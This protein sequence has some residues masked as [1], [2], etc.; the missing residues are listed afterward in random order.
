M[1]PEDIEPIQDQPYEYFLGRTGNLHDYPRKGCEWFD[2]KKW[3]KCYEEVKFAPN[4][5]FIPEQKYRR[6]KQ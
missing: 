3:G 2:G 4:N 6:K 1:K 5:R